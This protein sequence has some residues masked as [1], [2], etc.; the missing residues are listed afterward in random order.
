MARIK[1]YM[2]GSPDILINKDRDFLNKVDFYFVKVLC[3]NNPTI[4]RDFPILSSM[5][6][7]GIRNFSNDTQG[8]EFYLDKIALEDAENFQGLKFKIISGYFYNNGFNNKVNDIIQFLFNERL[9]QKKLG[10]P[11]EK[12]YKLLM[13]S[14]Y[15]KCLLKPID[16]DIEIVY[17]EKWGEYL[18]RN[19]NFIKEYTEIKDCY[20]VKKIKP[21]SNHFNNVSQGVYVLSM[22]K[23]IMNEVITTGED[24]NCKIYYTDTDSIHI[25]YDKVKVLETEFKIKYGRELTGK[26]L[27]QF[28]IDF[29]L[30]NSVGEIKSVKSIFLGK[31]C[32]MDV[33]ESKDIDGKIITGSHLRMK[34][35]P[36]QSINYTCKKLNKTP[37]ELYDDLYDNK[38]IKFNKDMS[39]SSMS[40]FVRQIS[41]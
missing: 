5:N 15:G 20:I 21:I 32:Y 37:Y 26:N 11:I 40:E 1:G 17:K 7:A 36:N 29:D 35:I 12:I 13:N 39:V 10:N 6:E 14:S 23:R 18:D 27:G 28:H 8:K 22:S 25:D 38:K 2:K 34:G 33:L 9:K 16:S 30:D 3:L 4:N 41:F 31:K 19:Y 24:N